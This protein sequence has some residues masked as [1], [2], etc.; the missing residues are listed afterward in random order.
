MVIC[1][2]P[3]GTKIKSPENFYGD[4]YEHIMGICLTETNVNFRNLKPFYNS[5][6]LGL[7]TNNK[8]HYRYAI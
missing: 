3:L 4:I 5:D 7:T 1:L 2:D 8:E 6:D